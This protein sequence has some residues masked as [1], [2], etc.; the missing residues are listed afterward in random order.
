MPPTRRQQLH[1][2][3]RAE[4]KAAAWKQAAQNGAAALSLSAIARAMGLSTP[5]LYRY[6]PGRAELLAAL[7]AD[8][9]ASFNTAL[10]SAGLAAEADAAASSAA[11]L[12]RLC[13]A[14]YAWALEHPQEY[15][16]IFGSPSA[17][18]DHLD[19]T[20]SLLADSCFRI[21]LDTL[22]AAADAGRLLPPPA[23]LPAGLRRQLESVRHAAARPYT[24]WALYLALQVWSFMHGITS[25][26]LYRRCSLL[27]GDQ[28]GAFID[29]E[30][31]RFLQTSGV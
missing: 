10:S 22:Q 29:Y 17:A 8:A 20:A 3:I 13:R 2:H 30:I 28:V 9:Y 19:P 14:Y 12:R 31:E 5:A 16:L 7:T 15:I 25:L 1:D 24:A 23:P 26:D 21:L 4:I 27:L 6:F 18:V 11:A